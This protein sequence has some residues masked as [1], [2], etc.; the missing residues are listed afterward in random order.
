[1]K[2]WAVDGLD[3]ALK[4]IEDFTREE[5]KSQDKEKEELLAALDEIKQKRGEMS[6]T[7]PRAHDNLRRIFDVE[8]RLAVLHARK[9]VLYE[10]G[11]KV[12]EAVR[13]G[14]GINY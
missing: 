11:G 14:T 9:R 5:L 2:H 7:D 3:G 4:A 13:E 10:L 8:K 12:N 6:V 1:M